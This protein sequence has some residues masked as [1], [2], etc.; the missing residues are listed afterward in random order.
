M[1]SK[2]NMWF[3]CCLHFSSTWIGSITLIFH[4]RKHTFHTR[5]VWSGLTWSPLTWGA[6]RFG[7]RGVSQGITQMQVHILAPSVTG[8]VPVTEKVLRKR[9]GETN[10]T[11]QLSLGRVPEAVCHHPLSDRCTGTPGLDSSCWH[12]PECCSSPRGRW[13]SRHGSQV[14]RWW[15]R[16]EK[17]PPT[18][19]WGCRRTEKPRVLWKP[20]EPPWGCKE[21]LRSERQSAGCVADENNL[22]S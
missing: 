6:E 10:K 20:L 11:Q 18:C 15:S 19:H 2:V 7:G 12:R 9:G 14:G 4:E 1:Q 16:K 17:I 3:L 21:W 13:Q 5:A 22:L 8:R